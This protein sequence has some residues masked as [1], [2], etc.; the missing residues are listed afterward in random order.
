MDTLDMAK[1]ATNK[2]VHQMPFY[3]LLQVC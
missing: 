3:Y 2:E 1:P